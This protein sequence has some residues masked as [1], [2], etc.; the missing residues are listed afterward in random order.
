MIAALRDPQLDMKLMVV[1]MRPSP[2]TLAFNNS[3]G[4]IYSTSITS[5]TLHHLHCAGTTISTTKLF[6]AVPEVI[7]LGHKY[8]YKGHIPDDSKMVHIWDWPPC[9][10]LTNVWAF[11][12]T[13]SFMQ[14]WIHNYSS[15]THPLVD[16]T[17]KGVTFIWQEQHEEAMQALKDTIIHLS[18]LI[19]INYASS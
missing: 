2:T 7:I 11:L 14:I 6:M 8:N 4:S 18:T 15:I 16:L 9:K 17:C 3:S 1:S 19:S 5:S 10:M 12:G 13:T